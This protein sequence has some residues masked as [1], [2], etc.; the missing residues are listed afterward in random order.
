MSSD[1]VPPATASDFPTGTPTS[2]PAGVPSKR[3][4]LYARTSTTEKKVRRLKDEEK[5]RQD[6]ETQLRPLRAYAGARG[7]SVVHEYIDRIPGPT[8]ARPGLDALLTAVDAGGVDMVLMWRFD[9]WGR[10]LR[11]LLD[12]LDRFRK[13]GVGFV[14]MTENLDTETPLGRAMFA[15]IG[16]FAELEH[17]TISERVKVGMARAREEGQHFG[18]PRR[19]VDLDVARRLLGSGMSLRKT[20]KALQVPYTTLYDRLHEVE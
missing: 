10:G 7:W 19:E 17:E 14:S 6:P 15:I 11:H 5:Q 1:H 13:L 16:A 8:T 20:A 18:R 9:R 12:T 3:V 4:A 2:T